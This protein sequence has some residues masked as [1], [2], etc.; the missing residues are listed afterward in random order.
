VSRSPFA[1]HASAY[2]AGGIRQ[3]ARARALLPL[4]L[5][6]AVCLA[7]VVGNNPLRGGGLA[8]VVVLTGL[9][10]LAVLARQPVTVRLGLA[11]AVTLTAFGLPWQ[12]SWWPLP[13][14]VGVAAYVLS[15]RLSCGRRADGMATGPIGW[16]RGR[17]GREQ[18]WA[19]AALSAAAG[20]ALVAFHALTPPALQFGAGL[21]NLLPAWSVLIAGAGYVSLTAAVEEVLFRG[22]ILSHL[23]AVVGSWPAL[24]VQAA[25]FGVLHLHGY[26]YGPIGVALA[27]G[28]GLLLGVMR[29]RSEGLLACW[30]A[31][32]LADSV[33][34][35]FILQAAARPL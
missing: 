12:L 24:V 34:F 25:G 4:G 20:G 18:V 16:R 32:V 11:L 27:T 29:L 33:I 1:P 7:P 21:I 10:L 17:F 2:L 30:V 35:V 8:V 28:Y 6:G 26:P 14:V 13:G 19:I 22:V 15:G 3:S 5:V 9:T 31:H 23:T